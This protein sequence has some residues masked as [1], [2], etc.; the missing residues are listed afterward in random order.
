MFYTKSHE[1]VKVSDGL[2]RVGITDHAQAAL[3]D[4]VYVDLPDVEG[5]FEAGEEVSSVES[6]KAVGDVALPVSGI[7]KAVNEALSDSPTLVNLS[8]EDE[9]DLAPKILSLPMRA[10]THQSVESTLFSIKLCAHLICF[11][12]NN[13]VS[14]QDLLQ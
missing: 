6:V 1:W 11:L 14:W 3:G 9:G 7:V 13:F 8:A 2:G 12:F 10:L 4:I 5:E